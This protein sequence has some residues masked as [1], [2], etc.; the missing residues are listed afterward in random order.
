MLKQ[1]F[2][3]LRDKLKK[4]NDEDEVVKK[5]R[6]RVSQAFDYLSFYCNNKADIDTEHLANNEALRILNA[7][8]DIEALQVTQFL[9]MLTHVLTFTFL[10]LLL[11]LLT[12]GYMYRQLSI[13]RKVGCRAFTVFCLKEFRKLRENTK[14]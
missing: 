9:E 12:R 8:S 6:A 14:V 11:S 2:N 10:C 7:S 4:K 5:A 13:H 3:F 1:R